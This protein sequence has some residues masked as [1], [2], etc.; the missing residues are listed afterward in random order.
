[1]A[2]GIAN[3]VIKMDGVQ[4]ERV[5]RGEENVEGNVMRNRSILIGVKGTLYNR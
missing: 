4:Y 2:F 5:F 1:M 3:K